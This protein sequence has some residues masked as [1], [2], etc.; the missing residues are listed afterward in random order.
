M[1]K[2]LPDIE[3]INN[4]YTPIVDSPVSIY[5][6]HMYK[7]EKY[8]ANLESYV[9][10]VKNIERM[11]RSNDRYKK[12][13]D[14][15]KKKV[16]LNHCQV[17]SKV[18]DDEADIEMHHGPIL[19]LYDYC[20]IILEYYLIKKWS[21]STLRIAD[22]VLSEHEK[23]RIQVVMLSSTIHQEVHDRNIFLNYE[24]GFGDFNSFIKKYNIALGNI[25]IE[26]INRYIDRSLMENSND[27]GILELS[28]NLVVSNKKRE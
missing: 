4:K 20:A 10:F 1:P 24:Q 23:N 27:F 5:Q 21:I 16:G 9:S 28:K 14:Y 19:T 26:K 22:T 17:L 11:V 12:Y 13:I 6:I 2:T 25:Y 7:N 18:T 15:L 3:Y 8:F